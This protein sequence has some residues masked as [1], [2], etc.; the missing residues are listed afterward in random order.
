MNSFARR[1][2]AVMGAQ[3]SGPAPRIPTAYQEVEYIG[4]SGSN[5]ML[6]TGIAVNS[7]TKIVAD[8][9]KTS[10]PSTNSGSVF[11]CVRNAAGSDT[12]ASSNWGTLENASGSKFSASPSHTK[13]QTFSKTTI[14]STK[15]TSSSALDVGIGYNTSKF[16]PGLRFYTLAVYNGSTLL[17][18]GVPCY[19]KSDSKIGMYDLVGKSFHASS[20]S[21]SKGSDVI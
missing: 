2:R 12:P 14:T 3:E 20:G 7:M 9:A 16:C 4:Y 10:L 1:R 15:T 19:R 17:F 6:Y 21:W 8:I 18:D 5:K 13:E 11:P